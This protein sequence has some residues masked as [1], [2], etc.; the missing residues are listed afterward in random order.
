MISLVLILLCSYLLGS[1]SPSI[2]LSRL[3]KGVDI[4]TVGS[5]N[6][7]MTNAIRLLG[8]KWGAVVAVIDMAKGFCASM[9]VTSVF[10][11]SV[12]IMYVDETLLRILACVAVVAGHIWTIFFG[13]KGGKGV[14]TIA[15]G[16]L[17]VAPIQVGMCLVI[18]LIIFA[19]TRYISLGSVL[20]SWF[21]AIEVFTQK[22]ILHDPISVYLLWF[23][24]FVA[25]LINY[26]HRENVKRLLRGE[27]KKFGSRSAFENNADHPQ[28]A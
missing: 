6:A 9:V 16:V 27:E 14:L 15:G 26:T 28:K 8:G 20:G 10:Y 24:L 5:G 11:E 25:L 22:Y 19:L 12:D 18:F 23:S 21:F 13:F 3:I 7:G 17:G 1:I 2:I 4:R